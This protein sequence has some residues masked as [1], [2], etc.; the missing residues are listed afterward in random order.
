MRGTDHRNDTLLSYVRPDSR[1]PPNHPLRP[2][3]RITD[4]ALKFPS[5]R[6]DAIMLRS[7]AARRSPPEK[8]L[9]ALLLLQALSLDP[10]GAA[11]HG[12]MLI[13]L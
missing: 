3:R 12:S 5:D 1:V 7:S 10:F 4:I 9:R 8:L 6:F 2:I 13:G 11:A